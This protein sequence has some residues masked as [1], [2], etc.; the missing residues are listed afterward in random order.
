VTR[1]LLIAHRGD[2]RHAPENTL[3]AFQAALDADL[4]GIELDV[5]ASADGEAIVLH[6]PTLARVQGIDARADQQTA[7][8]LARLGVPR[9]A[10]VLDLVPPEVVLDIELK[11]PVVAAVRAAVRV[12]RG[13]A[14]RGLVFSSFDAAFL[15]EL[16]ATEPTWSRWL[17]DRSATAVARASALGCTGVALDW[18]ALEGSTVEVAR[19]AGLSLMAWTIRDPKTL[20]RVVD[21]GVELV[22]LEGEALDQRLG[23]ASGGSSH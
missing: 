1:P 10:E 4:D 20:D 6:D 14:A 16:A 19:G 21:L 9:L 7:D 2:H 5:R 11:E 15:A 17:I 23:R 18:R 3:S 13:A 8:E 12:V 22:C